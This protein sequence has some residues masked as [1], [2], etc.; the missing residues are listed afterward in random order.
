MLSSIPPSAVSSH[1]KTTQR[2]LNSEPSRVLS[3]REK[4]GLPGYSSHQRCMVSPESMMSSMNS[5][6]SAGSSTSCKLPW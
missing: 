2:S 6:A 5:S 4:N 3:I 1:G